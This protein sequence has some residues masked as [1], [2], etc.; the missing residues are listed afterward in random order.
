MSNVLEPTPV[1]ASSTRPF[2]DID[3]DAAVIGNISDA[4]SDLVLS[5]LAVVEERRKG[6]LSLAQASLQLVELLPDTN[7]GIKACDLFGPT[8]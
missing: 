2:I 1:I 8:H 7:T 5:C 6:N 4:Q 3:M